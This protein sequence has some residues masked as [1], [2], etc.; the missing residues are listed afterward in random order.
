MTSTPSACVLSNSF[1]LTNGQPG[2]EL[3]LEM[4]SGNAYLPN[5]GNVKLVS[6]AE[7]GPYCT[8]VKWDNVNSAWVELCRNTLTISSLATYS[9]SFSWNGSLDYYNGSVQTW[10]VPA[11]ATTITV[12]IAGASGW[13]ADFS[14]GISTSTSSGG[15]GAVLTGSVTLVPGDVLDIIVG[16]VGTD[17]TCC[18][19]LSFY[20]ASGGGASYIW[21]ATSSTILVVAGGGGGSARN[22]R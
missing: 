11:C 1:S 5:T 10:T 17:P 7:F 16:G 2:Q 3:V 4:A 18:G 6:N 12:T 22:N 19:P 15:L 20:G 9:T 13:N 14:N 21:D 8:L